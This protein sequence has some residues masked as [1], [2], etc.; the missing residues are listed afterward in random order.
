MDG[1]L[2][3]DELA[4]IERRATKATPG[5]WFVRWLDDDAAMNLVAVGTEPD[6][7]LHE[8]YPDF[9]AGTMVALTVVQDPLYALI[10]DGREVENA[11]FIAHAR[12]DID[13]LLAE[14]RTLRG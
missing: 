9:D 2:T 5:P 3:D 6:T 7:G 12:L 1:P 4:A 11:E 8:R 14:V 13:R 10:S